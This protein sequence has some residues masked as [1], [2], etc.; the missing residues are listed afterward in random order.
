MAIDQAILKDATR[1]SSSCTLD[2]GKAE[3]A[4]P[5][6]KAV[7]V[8]ICEYGGPD[9]GLLPPTS[10]NSKYCKTTLIRMKYLVLRISITKRSHG[11]IHQQ[12]Q[13]R[14]KFSDQP[15]KRERYSQIFTLLDPRE[16]CLPADQDIG[17]AEG[18]RIS[19][20]EGTPQPL[21]ALQKSDAARAGDKQSRIKTGIASSKKVQK[22][23]FEEGQSETI[24]QFR[25]SD[26]EKI[27]HC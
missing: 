7:V 27:K 23:Q 17:G 16:S 10:L 25:N 5:L 3:S 14:M 12:I 18:A 9:A 22:K 15:G 13:N 1:Y 11:A 19:P 20:T 8:L 26:R 21:R 6:F 4:E 24:H 2:S